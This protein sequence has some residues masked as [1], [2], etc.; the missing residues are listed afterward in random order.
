VK[1]VRDV[2]ETAGGEGRKEIKTE[3]IGI[4]KWKR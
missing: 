2:K 1:R 3:I 4:E